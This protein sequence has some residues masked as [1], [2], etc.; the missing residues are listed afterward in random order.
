M[1]SEEDQI[2][3]LLL[4]SHIMFLQRQD[5]MC[6]IFVKM[7]WDF[8]QNVAASCIRDHQRMAGQGAA[9]RLS[10]AYLFLVQRGVLPAFSSPNG[11]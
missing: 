5:E 8:C 1:I 9:S 2:S 3:R 10:K 6:A 7:Q 4:L 11:A